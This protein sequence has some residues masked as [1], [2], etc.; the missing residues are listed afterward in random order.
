MEAN[1]MNFFA[2]LF[3]TLALIIAQVPAAPRHRPATGI[4]LNNGFFFPGDYHVPI[5]EDTSENIDTDSTDDDGLG[6]RFSFNAEC[7]EGFKRVRSICRR[8]V[9]TR[10]SNSQMCPRNE[11]YKNG[12]CNKI[13]E[14]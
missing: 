13:G 7:K 12:R 3:V 8:Q 11:V 9:P 1:I 10:K 14:T 2:I 6:N 5:D 4:S